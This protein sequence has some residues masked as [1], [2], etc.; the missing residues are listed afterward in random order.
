[1]EYGTIRNMKYLLALFLIFVS[2]GGNAQ[3]DYKNIYKPAVYINL[4]SLMWA[5][6]EYDPEDNHFLD[7][8]LQITEC[9]MYK[10][11]YQDDFKWQIIR[12]GMKR[13]L[14]YFKKDLS[15]YLY[16][17]A[18]L[19]LGRYD[20]E[21]AAFEISK[22]FSLANAGTIRIPFYTKIPTVCGTQIDNNIFP[23]RIKFFANNKFSLTHIPISPDDA[24]ALIERLK[25][26]R[27]ENVK[28]TRII[29]V[30]FRLKVNGI[31]AIN[32]LMT[33]SE[34]VFKGDLVEI[35]F[36]EDPQMTIELWSKKFRELPSELLKP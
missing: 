4:S 26:Y 9:E 22:E 27:Y 35:V 20:F 12:E 17:N 14:A 8:Y 21:R 13:E 25:Q 32:A 16:V 7:T 19:P 36:F 5:F 29:P 31:K 23:K 2:A 30:Q 28:D 10:K 15:T 24:T 6:D 11:Y 33:G 3:E 1:M 34:V 18:F